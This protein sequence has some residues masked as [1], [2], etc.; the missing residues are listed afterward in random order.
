M[1]RKK[2]GGKA[3]KMISPG[4]IIASIVAA[5]ISFIVIPKIIDAAAAGIYKKLSTPDPVPDDEDWGP[6]I[7]RKKSAGSADDCGTRNCAEAE[8]G[9]A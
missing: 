5:G 2:K 6:V 9:D 1:K 8:E 4:Y 7:V 3:R